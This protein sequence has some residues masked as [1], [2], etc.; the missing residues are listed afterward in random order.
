MN[1]RYAFQTESR[2]YYIMEEISNG[3]ILYDL[4]KKRKRFREDEVRLIVAEI[5]MVIDYLHECKSQESYT[6]L[7]PENIILDE[8]GHVILK[9]PCLA[10]KI[11][12][13]RNHWMDASMVEYLAPEQ[14]Q[15]L[16]CDKN[17]DCWDLGVLLYELTVGNVPFYSRDVNELLVMIKKAEFTFPDYLSNDCKDLIK[18]L[19]C[20][21]V[22][23][24]IGAGSDGFGEI[25]KHSFFKGINWGK[26][27][28]KKIE[29]VFKHGVDEMRQ[30]IVEYWIR[31]E[32]EQKEF[33]LDVIPIIVWFC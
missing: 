19:L 17:V 20:L 18:R 24:R 29:P 7:A 28:E 30:I 25:K 33:S 27:H 31:I 32:M 26:L 6:Y 16:P 3:K 1:D 9:D 13:S 8:D 4:M 5:A 15:K 10:Q 22:K 23:E 12:D 14:I 11:L 21:E 2:L